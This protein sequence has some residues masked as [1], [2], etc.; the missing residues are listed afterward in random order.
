MNL[1]IFQYFFVYAFLYILLI[2]GTARINFEGE[3][4][5]KQ[6]AKKIGIA[7]GGGGTRGIAHLGAIRVFQENHIDF[8]YVSGNSAGAIA[9]AL[10]AANIPWQELYDFVLDIRNKNV[11]PKKPWFSYLSPELIEKLAD[12]FLKDK[13]FS[14]LEKPFCATAV[15]LERGELDVLCKGRLSQALSASCAVPGIFQPVKIGRNT[16]I[17]GG[18]LRN[19]PTETVREMGADAV[20]GINLNADRGRGTKSMRRLDILVTAYN[21]SISANDQIC[22]RYADIML[23]PGLEMYPRYSFRN[24]EN[25]LRIGEKAVEENLEQVQELTHGSE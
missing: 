6:K 13:K 11:L 22:E 25:M 15:E 8:D 5:V 2:L 16:Y 9:G 24:I 21:L 12:C 1:G 18:T 23:E 20:V 10:Y 19:I 3:I 4:I 14:D 17:D 7:L